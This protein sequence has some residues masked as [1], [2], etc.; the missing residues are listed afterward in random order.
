MLR[1]VIH[2]QK[3]YHDELQEQMQQIL[4]DQTTLQT[5]C[6]QQQRELEEAQQLRKQLLRSLEQKDDAIK[7]SRE[8]YQLSETIRLRTEQ[9]LN[10]DTPLL[11]PERPIN[12]PFPYENEQVQ[13]WAE[14]NDDDL[15]DEISAITDD[16]Y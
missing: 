7:S 11:P 4:Q 5:C 12:I 13:Q 1:D 3:A 6:E 8:I 14:T 10:R 16:H 9:L 15:E 2:Q